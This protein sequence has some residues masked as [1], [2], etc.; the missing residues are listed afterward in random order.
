MGGTAAD[1]MEWGDI[2][3]EESKTTLVLVSSNYLWP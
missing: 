1:D 3:G 2:D